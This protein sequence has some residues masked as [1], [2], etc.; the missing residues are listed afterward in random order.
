MS[1]PRFTS[2]DLCFGRHSAQFEFSSSGPV[3]IVGPN[4]SGKTTLV[5][6]LFR[7]VY[8]FRRQRPADRELLDSRRPWAGGAYEASLRIELPEGRLLEWS[9]DF[10]TDFVTVRLNDGTVLFEGE[11]RP[12]G[13]GSTAEDY[14]RLVTS[15]FG[16]DDLEDLCRTAWTAQGEL[17]DT[18]FDAGLLSLVEGGHA[19][20]ESALGSISDA[21]KELTKAP[22]NE[23]GRALS[24]NRRLEEQVA[25]LE[26]N[27]SRLVVARSL[28]L[29]RGPALARLPEIER[30]EADLAQAIEVLDQAHDDFLELKAATAEAGLARK[31]LDAVVELR[32]AIEQAGTEEAAAG[33][34]LAV[35]V[36]L[37]EYPSDFGI[38]ASRLKEAWEQLA[39]AGA[40]GPSSA[41][42]QTQAL[43]A[44]GG[45]AGLGFILEIAG[46]PAGRLAILVGL[47]IGVGA[48]IVAN[49]HKGLVSTRDGRKHSLQREIKAILEGVPDAETI[50]A[51]TLP[52]RIESFE[53]QRTS[54]RRLE[55][56]R[57]QLASLERRAEKLAASAGAPDRSLALLESD[58]ARDLDAIETRV[59][60]L[61]AAIPRQLPGG[62]ER[63]PAEVKK[64]VDR[65]RQAIVKLADE[66][67]QLEVQLA[68]S[69][70]TM[71]VEALEEERDV[72]ESQIEETRRS[73]S[74]HRRA[75]ALIREGYAEFR[76]QD[77]ERLIESVASRLRDLGGPVFGG[78]QA[79][80]GL[81]DP[82]V[83][84][85]TRDVGLDSSQ[86]SHGQ[87]LVAKLAVRI[88]TADFL[89]AGGVSAPLVVDDP[90]AHLDDDNS[91]RV[92]SLLS[93][94]AETRQVIVT[95][96]ET[97]LLARLGVTEGVV[98]LGGE[99]SGAGE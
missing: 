28:D 82:R 6:A 86:L 34:E 2:I 64:E 58:A 55:Q 65:L 62:V 76:E 38:R 9:R 91:A 93:C 89:A 33:R 37:G 51:E 11:A 21:H 13:R 26:L 74:A 7:T 77:E 59:Q 29:S 17:R 79:S 67:R 68:G 36:G 92:W 78:F 56:A 23:A 90:F 18:A 70:Q 42:P 5:D 81:G 24:K 88:G 43:W 63:V 47:V 10:H 35:R 60:D 83:G 19:R 73:I 54:L 50:T 48:L 1:G 94:V 16:L 49:R 25:E 71:G 52:D 61:E 20:V 98:E 85:G 27:Q 31:Q 45:L 80:D 66:R 87:Q 15:V 99:A 95:T 53:R 8:G 41:T 32:D 22:I 30:E 40:P 14:S 72:L 75:Y 96:Q 69:A 44:A 4:G 84:I 57:A 39:E 97:E 46:Q 3:V 12:G